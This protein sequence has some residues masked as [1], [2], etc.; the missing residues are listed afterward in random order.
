MRRYKIVI[1]TSGKSRGSN[2]EAIANYFQRKKLPIEISAVVITNKS[3]PII[4]KCEHFR[5]PH[6][7]ISCKD[8]NYYQNRLAEYIHANGI[9][10]IVL[11]GFMKLLK[12]DFITSIQIP[13]LNIHPA[14]LPK[15]GGKGMYGINVH[16]AVYAKRERFSGITIHQV[17]AEYDQGDIVFQ[18]R[19]RVHRSKSP[20]IIA[21][22]VLKQ[23]HK[24]YGQVISKFLKDIY[25]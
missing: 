21:Q 16:Q 1:L 4:E 13:I 17:N 22:K 23:E 2:F 3:A 11:A 6:L 7:F 14:L 19:I 12:Q 15:F 20:E 5:I 8:I 24:Y 25:E 10:L 18:K 9:N